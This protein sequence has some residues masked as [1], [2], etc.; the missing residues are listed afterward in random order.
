MTDL[1]PKPEW[2][3]VRQLEQTDR[4]IAGPGGVMNAQA[5]ALLNRTEFLNNE[6]ASNDQVMHIEKKVSNKA[7]TEYV[8]QKVA[9]IE[10]GQ[11]GTY[12]TVDESMLFSSEWKA[13]TSITITADGDKSGLYRWDGYNLIRS[14]YDPLNL[15]NKNAVELNAK[16]EIKIKE[17]GLLPNFNDSHFDMA[18]TDNQGNVGFGITKDSVAL[19]KEFKANT[20][21][22]LNSKIYESPNKKF[23]FAVNDSNG[24]VGFGITDEAIAVAK[25]FNAA[26][27]SIQDT[28]IHELSNTRFKF[29]ITDIN[30]NVVFGIENDGSLFPKNNSETIQLLPNIKQKKTDVIGGGTYGQSLSRGS[31]SRPVVSTIQVHNN[32][33]FKSGVLP[34]ESDPHDYSD[35]KPLVEERW[36]PI[37]AE[38]ESPTSGMLNKISE[39]AL[40]GDEILTF[41]GHSGGQG[42]TALE[43]LSKGTKRYNEQLIMYQSAFNLCQ[44]RNLS[45]SVGYI[46][47]VQGESNYNRGNSRKDYKQIEVK[48]K[49][50]FDTDIQ[51]ITNQD[52]VPIMLTYQTASHHVAVPRRDHVNIALAQLDA[53]RENVDIVMACSMYA[54]EYLTDNLHLTAD[55]SQQL[56]K[57]LGKAAHHMWRYV[58]DQEPTPFRPLEPE[59]V[60]WQGKVIDIEFNVPVGDLTLDTD[61]VKETFN[62]GFDIWID[63]VVQENAIKSAS[64]VD[65]NRVRI[66]L[67]QLYENAVLSYARGRQSE[68]VASGP[69]NG[70]RGNIRDQAGEAD[71]YL[72]SKNNRRYMH[73]WCVIFQYSQ[74]TGFN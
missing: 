55:S 29:A 42:G 51:L 67:N 6:K 65:K 31:G 53:H 57:Y 34:R 9:A 3:A 11:A 1:N 27:L 73:N 70:P 14:E 39:L 41:F 74:T 4:A 28:K 56:G 20:F 13:N 48:L 32:I 43:N 54:I 5:Q 62:Y 15:A 30:G 19:A 72:D 7:D 40:R 38:G 64:I 12:A 71:N 50:D 44:S 59:H 35:T 49:R 10:N 25:E 16:T 58:H 21:S 2:S 45:Y 22:I 26:R 24:N 18:V 61:L 60:L 63:D 8:D 47:F 23:E 36:N 68:P 17:Q 46:G 69:I 33:T 37:G 66:V 52:F